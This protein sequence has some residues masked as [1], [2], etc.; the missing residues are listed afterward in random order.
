M[1]ELPF[2]PDI[3][4]F[5]KPIE[6]GD[7]NKIY[8]DP[9]QP[10]VLIRVPV[11]KEARF[12]QADPKLIG[13]A[14]KNYSRIANLGNELGI[15]VA[16]HQFILAK[17]AQDG[18][19]K[20]M[21]LAERIEGKHLV[22]IDRGNPKTLDALSRI[23]QL[24]LKYLRWA[25]SSAPKNVVTDIFRPEQYLAKPSSGRDLLYLVDIEPRLMER[26]RGT[27]FIRHSLIMLVAPLR[28]TQHDKTFGQVLHGALLSLK[29]DR[30]NT[31]LLSL[32]NV[33]VN[34]PEGY[35]KMSEEYLSPDREVTNFSPAV[36]ERLRNTPLIIDR[37]LLRSLGIE[38]L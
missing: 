36:V 13:I 6:V 5:E 4:E 28:G 7:T 12:L 32:L 35:Q 38:K 2:S 34:Y 9:S 14:E 3:R 29:Q 21:L 24:G 10:D 8:Y 20:P 19:V 17:E 1:R 22:P 16:R 18:P 23:A 11:D 37:A 33:I 25:E 31:S 30:S 15:A 26:T 27:Q